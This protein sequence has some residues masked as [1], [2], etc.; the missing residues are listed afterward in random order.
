MKRRTN[1]A[2]A[3]RAALVLLMT[4]TAGIHAQQGLNNLWMGG[5]ASF[6]DPPFGGMDLN[7]LSGSIEISFM[8]RDIEYYRTNSN[9]SGTNG[10]LL[11]ST[12]GAFVANALGDT[13]VNGSGLNPSWY[14]SQYPDGLLITQ[15]VLIIPRPEASNTFYLLHMTI[16]DWSNGSA[17]QLYC[18]T[19]EA[20]SGEGLGVVT[21]KNVPVIIDELNVGKIASVR[22]ANGRDWWIF[23]HKI[24]T[25]IFYRL[26]LTPEG[27]QVDGVQSIG[28]VRPRDAGQVCFSPDGTKF[29][30][31]WADHGLEVFEFDRCTGLFAE[32]RF[33]MVEDDLELGIGVAFSPNSRFVYATTRVEVFQYDTEASVLANSEVLI[34]QWDSTYSPYPPFAAKFDIAQL[35]PDGKIYIGTGNGT[36]VLHV[37]HNPDEPGLAC[38]MEQ[39]G[40]DLERYFSNSL[41]NHP[42]YHLGPVDGSVCDSLGINTGIPP[43]SPGEGLVVRASP[44]PSTGMFAVH[45]PALPEA[46][47]L[48]VFDMQGRVLHQRRLPPWSQVQQVYL[49]GAEGLYHCRFTWGDH[50]R[51]TRIIITP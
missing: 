6:A 9:I 2:R 26:L 31:Y 47:L 1:F 16:D 5:Y 45:Y 37:I 39:H 17:S 23:C 10:D 49:Q 25:N 43:L 19:V 15:G 35:A 21:A 28:I 8:D 3:V 44:N 7:F 14:T 13:M 30:Y 38:N 18:T 50:Q 42:N 12:N 11:F 34:A 24:N 33:V 40:I 27:I 46:G 36:Q 48:E 51:S 32:P 22:H 41:P 20:D 4:G 29:A